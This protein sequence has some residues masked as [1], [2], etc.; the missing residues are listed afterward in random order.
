MPSLMNLSEEQL[1]ALVQN[2]DG[3][4]FLRQ[5]QHPEQDFTDDKWPND[6]IRVFLTSLFQSDGNFVRTILGLTFF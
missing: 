6:K 2:P 3:D 1:K 5:T 4:L